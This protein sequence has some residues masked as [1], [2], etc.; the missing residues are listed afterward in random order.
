MIIVD[1]YRDHGKKGIWCHLAST[2]S[3]AE[4]H[5]F[6]LNIGVPFHCFQPYHYDL[7]AGWRMRA[8][9]AGAKA[10]S[11]AQLVKMMKPRRRKKR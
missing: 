7:T 1:S 4:I 6:A 2:K 11:A 9:A 8:I 3:L 5:A 10:V